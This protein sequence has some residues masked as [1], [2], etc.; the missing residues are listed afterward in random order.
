[1]FISCFVYISVS[2]HLL[3]VWLILFLATGFVFFWERALAGIQM[4]MGRGLLKAIFY[5]FS[6]MFLMCNSVMYCV[7]IYE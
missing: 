5:L 3:L 4:I 1:M 7:W 6:C 2:L